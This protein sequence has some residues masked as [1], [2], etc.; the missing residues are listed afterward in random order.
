VVRA[1]DELESV[2]NT[3]IVIELNALATAR[4]ES[5]PAIG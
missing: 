4:N 1:L 5:A 2:L 3:D